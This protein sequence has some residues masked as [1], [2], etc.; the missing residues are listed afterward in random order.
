MSTLP[1]DD[2]LT[3]LTGA[4]PEGMRL[5]GLEVFNWGTF[6]GAVWKLD[7]HGRNCLVTG[8]IGAGKST[9]VDAL[10]VLLAPADRVTFNKAAGADTRER[11]LT[12][13]VL[14]QYSKIQDEYGTAKPRTLRRRDNA[15]S[16]L[17]ATFR[18][19]PDSVVSC[20]C[21]LTFPD[22]T[23]SPNK[24]FVIA[25]G[26][27]RISEHFSGYDD[28]RALRA[29]LRGLGAQVFDN[30]FAA[31]QRV[32]C[33]QLGVK[34]EALALLAT[35]VSMKQVGDLTGFV[36]AHMLDAPAVS[37]DIDRMLSHYADLTHAHDTVVDARKQKAALD[38]VAEVARLYEQAGARIAAYGQARDAV[39]A[40]VDLVRA[41]LLREALAD[42]DRREP[43]LDGQID[44]LRTRA[45]ALAERI[46]QLRRALDDAGG[47]ELDGAKRAV[48]DAENDLTRVQQALSA[49]TSLAVTAGVSTPDGDPR[50]FLRWRKEIEA[51]LAEAA[52]QIDAHKTEQFHAW[53]AQ[54]TATE[55]LKALDEEL[56]DAGT[57]ASN[58]PVDL[59]RLREE[60]AAA[61]QLPP[62]ELPY[63]GEMIAVAPEHSAWEA[64]AERLV[65]PFA[66][67]L[68][69]PE[70]RYRDVARYVNERH[71]GLRLVYYP[72]PA[73]VAREEVKPGSIAATLQLRTGT[74]TSA[75]LA[76]EVAR[77]F[78][79][80][81]VAD[82]AELA[83][84]D[85]GVTLA[86]QV[87]DG[88]RHEKNDR[89]RADDRRGY[90]LGWETG[91]RRAAL[92]SARIGLAQ[93]VAEASKAGDRVGD[94]ARKLADR[95]RA[96]EGLAERY[97]SADA[98]DVA[99][100]GEALRAAQRHLAML[101]ND[102]QITRLQ[103]ELT[104]QQDQ[105]QTLGDL[106]DVRKAE[107]TLL[108]DQRRKHQARLDRISVVD[109]ALGPDAQSA[110]D[111]ALTEQPR[112]VAA[113]LDLELCE[114]WQQQLTAWLDGRRESVGRTRE[115]HQH[116]LSNAMDR[117]A[118]GWPNLIGEI[119][120]SEIGAYTEL[121]AIRA[122][123]IDDDL[124]RFEQEFRTHLESN[125]IQEIAVFAN[126]LHRLA[127]SIS[128]RINTINSALYGT[129]YRD[130][131]FIKLEPQPTRDVDV[132]SFKADMK[133]ITEGTLGEDD[134]D[135]YSESRFLAVR[136]LL[137]RFIGR[138]EFASADKN[139]V[140]KVTD[141]RNWFV[142]GATER[143]RGD[144][145]VQEYFSDS[146]GKS[147]GQKEKLAYT[148]L[149]AS[150]AYQYGLADGDTR[151]FRFVM[152]DE[153]F[154]RGSDESTR[155]GL[156]MFTSLGLQLLVVT[157]Q[158]K[159]NV[160]A[161]YVN[162]V[163]Y[164]QNKDP[165]SALRSMSIGEYYEEVEHHLHAT[166]GSRHSDGPAYDDVAQQTSR[167]T[168]AGVRL[169]EQ[170]VV[171]DSTPA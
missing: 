129:D 72:V 46:F 121:L 79:H 141:V 158:Q 169:A 70:E 41:E 90:V 44:Q 62:S 75:W 118:S 119:A 69:V 91:A 168:D 54:S 93:D 116:R 68:L 159:V 26:E 85:R 24:T 35:T 33:R 171:G 145:D 161:P 42:A 122:R 34:K 22:A 92:A 100:G 131:T 150:L 29:G 66:L 59:A 140:T 11:T 17:L 136:E 137:D 132:I 23:S 84:V 74:A 21:V 55:A 5:D 81:C 106:L 107:L 83:R 47:S 67:S 120:T 6:D 50:A 97:V 36:R 160:I 105:H 4:L 139:W 65:R 95:H 87:R 110:L 138:A 157:P 58:I 2:A 20:A 52:D 103:A 31:Y 167:R 3:G 124:P 64:A 61:L 1:F 111:E 37:D 80:E 149:A 77:R 98:L 125:A 13:Y 28:M 170:V 53:Q 73:R 12:T 104:E 9:L 165:R 82:A 8:Q 109:T 7:A 117:F 19:G 135:V 123:L 127:D 40:H 151:A 101:T 143:T 15:Q 128:L 25:E 88:L 147:G 134:G 114:T 30:N 162:T 112:P 27:L 18:S 89:V 152:I 96:L 14:G 163:G 133:R 49:V 86:G 102:P 32:L 164:V 78:R 57:R 48:A 153:A 45:S 115:R 60:I 63:A 43:L 38:E 76:A 108:L 71:L 156:T 154:G 166:R 56:R 146:D 99:A 10:T 130:G 155:F 94:H 142:F 16:I 144:E 113:D 148:I 126:T 39:P 51:A